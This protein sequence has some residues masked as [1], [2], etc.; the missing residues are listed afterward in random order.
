[1][2]V[3]SFEEAIALANA[4][5]YGLSAYVFTRDMKKLMALTR[6][7]DFGEVYV[8]RGG[9]ESVQGFHKGYRNSGLGGEDGKYG[10]DAYV[11]SKTFYVNYG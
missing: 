10:L 7:L 8:N 6:E 4:S 9:G 3:E 5:E 11:K 2:K 1:M